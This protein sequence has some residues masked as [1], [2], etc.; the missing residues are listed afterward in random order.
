MEVQGTVHCKDGPTEQSLM[1]CKLLLLSVLTHWE[2]WPSLPNKSDHNINPA[3]ASPPS[4][5]TATAHTLI[6][7]T[8][9]TLS[10]MPFD[11]SLT[12]STLKWLEKVIVPHEA[13]AKSLITDEAIRRD[14]LRLY[15][16]T[17]EFK[18]QTQ[19]TFKLD[20]LQ[21]F[22]T[23]MV[24]LLEVEKT[25]HT[26]VIKACLHSTTDDLVKRGNFHSHLFFF[27]L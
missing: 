4:L 6:Q 25:L 8:L 12:F 26:N 2:P 3:A 24:H 21:L 18:V 23:I 16:Q 13:I 10:D 17:C 7:W 11:G 19:S 22:T 14:L 1:T 20:T 5:M 27:S 15:H 9:K